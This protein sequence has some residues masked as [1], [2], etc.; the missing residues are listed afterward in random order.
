MSERAA[1]APWPEA[2]GLHLMPP[3]AALPAPLRPILRAADRMKSG[4]LAVTLPNGH[5]LI[6]RGQEPGPNAELQLHRNRLFRRVLL[7]GHLAF[8]EAYLD[9][10]WD[11]P[12][13]AALISYFARNEAALAIDG[14]WWTRALSRVLHRL[15]DNSKRGSR[16]NI[17]FHYDLG[18]NFYRL[19]LDPSMTYSSA[20]FAPGAE[21]LEAAQAEKYARM[22]NLIG[23]TPGDHVL[24]IGCGWGG[25][26]EH[27]A[28]QGARLTGLTLSKEQKAYAE[29]RLA[30]AGLADQVSI[31]LQDYRD[32][33]GQFDG[34]VSIEMIEAVGEAYWPVYFETLRARLKAG[35]RAALQAITIDPARFEPY[36]RSPDFIQRY[37]FPGGML[38][39]VE[40]LQQEAA[41][42]GLIWERLDRY[43]Q[44]YAR[45]LRLWRE[46]FE[47]AWDQIAP[48]GFDARF[49]RTWRYYL[50]YCEG[51]FDAG[52]IDVVQIGLR[53]AEG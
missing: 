11:S 42:A 15:R 12:D 17:A 4:N 31:R 28:R 10:D 19:W 26:A 32:V 48:L 27:A 40:R 3:T 14:R 18:N 7:G 29:A 20:V 45:T 49:R 13:L 2:P 51:G 25:F 43:G 52:S 44:D 23:L 22:A 38:P 36:R 9:G 50:A 41:R 5:R 46:R 16:R 24:E 37:I 8:A 30:A 6:V 1:S 47:A 34:I 21:T 35:G 33:P 39:T 53:R